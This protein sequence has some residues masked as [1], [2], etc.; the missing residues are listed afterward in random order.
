MTD[1]ASFTATV[2]GRVQ[3]V[4]FRAFTQGRA[5]QL[6]VSGY[7]RNLPDGSVEVFAEGEK[8]QLE[9]L[10]AYLRTGSPMSGVTEVVIDWYEYTGDYSGF[11]VRY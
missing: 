7:V 1:M 5:R 6:G 8:S 10:A 2:R 4:F 11:H 9:L 3:G